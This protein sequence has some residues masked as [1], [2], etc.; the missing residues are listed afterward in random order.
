[1][2]NHFIICGWTQIGKVVFKELVAGKQSV[3]VISENLED[4]SNIKAL[5]GQADI[6]I[7]HGDPSTDEALNGANIKEASTV[8]VCTEDDTKNLITSLNIREHNA[9]ARV[10]TSIL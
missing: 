1:M 9:N 2:K 6:S 8:V 4:D 7:V 10:I 5:Q 3:A